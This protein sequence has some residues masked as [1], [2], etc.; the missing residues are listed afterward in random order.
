LHHSLLGDKLPY[1]VG[2]GDLESLTGAPFDDES[3]RQ[4][5]QYLYMG[6]LD[7]NDTVG[8]PDSW[9]GDKTRLI[10]K[11]LGDPMMPDRWKRSQ[12]IISTLHLPIQTVT[13]NGICLS[14]AHDMSG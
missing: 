6:S 8:H 2:V 14:L 3:Y 4:V 10:K 1:P 12:E 7:P 9:D 11:L 5:S 13:Y